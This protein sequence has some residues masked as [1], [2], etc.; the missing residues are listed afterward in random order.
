M[1]DHSF[2]PLRLHEVP[3]IRCLRLTYRNH[4]E[5][6]SIPVPDVHVL[7]IKPRTALN[8]PSPAKVNI[9]VV[10][11]GWSSD[12]E[13]ELS[14]CSHLGDRTGHPKGEGDEV[15]AR[16]YVRQRRQRANSTVQ[17]RPVVFLNH[18]RVS[19]YLSSQGLQ[20][21][22]APIQS[23]PLSSHRRLSRTHTSCKPR[24]SWV[25]RQQYQVSAIVNR[26]P[27]PLLSGLEF[28]LGLKKQ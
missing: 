28:T 25:A 6:V 3:V 16:I 19:R 23:G 5:D 9:P 11:Q 22:I 13:P 1:F 18:A 12:Y 17:E 15:R 4:A 14:I 24:R 7:F 20:D 21:S 8:G 10:A 26:V 2:Y 27:L